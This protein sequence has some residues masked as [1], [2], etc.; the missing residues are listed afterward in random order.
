VNQ[1]VLRLD[2]A[3]GA[4]STGSDHPQRVGEAAR[5]SRGRLKSG[6]TEPG[7][8]AAAGMPWMKGDRRVVAA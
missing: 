4:A 7:A 6:R 8:M 1:S 5:S 3:V 2:Q